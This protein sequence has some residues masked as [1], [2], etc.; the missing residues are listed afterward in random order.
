MSCITPP[1][2]SNPFLYNE[3]IADLQTDIAT[4]GWVENIYPIADVGEQQIDE[5]TRIT[6]PVVFAADGTKNYINLFPDG[7]LKG[8]CFFELNGRYVIDFQEDTVTVPLFIVFFANL[9][10][11]ANRTDDFTDELAATIVGA[12]HSGTRSNDI[13]EVEV[14]QAKNEAY[15]RYGYSYEQ[16]K[17]LAYPYT[18]F[19]IAITVTANYVQCVE[20]GGFDP[21]YS[22]PC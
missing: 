12:L 22:N 15:D 17:D 8:L 4:V 21:S 16:L 10:N 6:T 20:P 19:K 3:I 9:K 18:A 7:K 5:N 13:P 2:L 11:I 1:T 14:V